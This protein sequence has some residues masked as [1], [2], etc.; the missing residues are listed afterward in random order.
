LEL[1]VDGMLS[2][3]WSNYFLDP[4]LS[5]IN[6]RFKEM[7]TASTGFMTN[8]I[9]LPPFLHF[10]SPPLPLS[11]SYLPVIH[12]F[13][14][15]DDLAVGPTIK[16]KIMMVCVIGGISFLEVAAMRYLSNE[17]SFPYTILI[18]TTALVNGRTFLESLSH[19]F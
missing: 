19:Q 9:P 10:L 17:P 5:L 11:E 13:A 6:L 7:D 16:K 4:L 14:D 12:S 3:K 15:E 8:S 18:A 2:L 1:L